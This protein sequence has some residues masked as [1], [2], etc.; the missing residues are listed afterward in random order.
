MILQIK[1][2]I[3]GL[4]KSVELPTD[5]VKRAE[6]NAQLLGVYQAANFAKSIIQQE[7]DWTIDA[8]K[9]KQREMFPDR[10]TD[11][12]TMFMREELQRLNLQK[13]ATEAAFAFADQFS[14]ELE[15]LLPESVLQAHET[16]THFEGM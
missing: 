4:F 6:A 15:V 12:S 13:E 14:H 8:I 3:T 7:L 16:E 5:R 10:Y 9:D 11:N 2:A 1:K